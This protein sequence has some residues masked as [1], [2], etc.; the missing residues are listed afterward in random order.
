MKHD[1]AHIIAFALEKS[2]LLKGES[3]KNAFTKQKM[4]AI[5]R[6]EQLDYEE[7]RIFALLES[8]KIDFI[9]LKGA[10]IKKLYPEPFMRTI[11]DIDILVHKE[12]LERASKLILE[13]LQYQDGGMHFHEHSLISKCGVHLE[14]HFTVGENIEKLDKLLER[15][16]EFAHLCEGFTH[17]FEVTNE[18]FMF[19]NVAHMEYHFVAGGC[20][21]RPFIDLMLMEEK[22][23][24]S[25]EALEELL[26]QT[27]SVEFYKHVKKLTAVWFSG[28]AHNELTVMMQEFILTGGLFGTKENRVSVDIH[29]KGNRKN[30]LISRIFMPKSELQ[31]IYPDLKDKPYLLPYYTVKRW[32]RLLKKK[33]LSNAKGEFKA[34]VNYDASS[35]RTSE[36]LEKLGL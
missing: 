16:W 23:D 26:S 7:E 18:F 33:G 2:N 15:I 24:Y 6:R 12:D 28:E 4:L 29:R 31:S 10:L 25:T 35:D 11:C 8:E 22:L 27:K 19:H 21:V 3:A 34:N 9:P 32:F 5:F 1:L 14:L 17:R 30:Y 36:M 20:G 13:K